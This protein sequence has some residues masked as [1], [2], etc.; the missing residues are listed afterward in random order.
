M[1]TSTS[2]AVHAISAAERRYRNVAITV[3]MLGVTMSGIDTSAVVLGLPVMMRDLSSDLVSMV[4]VIMAYLL[5]ITIL[6]TQVGRLGDMFGRVRMY[7]LGFASFTFGS[8]LCGL[9]ASGPQLIGFRV[10]QGLGG[11][12]IYSNSGAIIADTFPQN[13]RGKAF[14]IT[15]TGWSLGAILGILV[16]GA[17][18]TFLNWRYIFFINLPIGIVATTVGFLMLSERSPRIR[19]KF[20]IIGMVILGTSLF[21]LLLGMTN[22]TG[23]G[24]VPEYVVEV[25]AGV[26]LLPAFV[27]YERRYSS[28]LLDLSLLKQRVLTASIFAAFLQSL[29]SFAVLFLVI[30][31]LQG[32]RDMT[33]WNA[34]LLLIPGYVLGGMIAPVAGRLSDRMGAR[35]V[36]SAGLALQAC[37]FL[38]YLTLGLTTSTYVVVVGAILN[39]AGSSSFFP[40]NNSAVMASAPSRAYGVV[41]GLLR[42]FSNVG[43][44]CSFAVALLVAS[45]SIPRQMAFEIFLGVGR[46]Q[47]S[48]S[49]AFVTGMHAALAG[50]I[51][52]I[53][54][55]LILS[56]LRGKEARTVRSPAA[57]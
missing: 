47:G 35:V 24:F 29:A 15:G 12:L 5:V 27:A 25:A 45:L 54:V 32:P 2:G 11:S 28:P 31:Y 19:A 3:V 37:G 14:G 16:G 8:L 9:S 57:A 43:M 26:V 55:A 46:I 34:S 36:A 42:T 41:S 17:F 53:I 22:I 52:V 13:E 20:D 18:V 33:P 49:S 21:F 1:S 56:V 30:M 7:N 38:V 4:W 51:S 48:L 40:A 10:V 23:S 50:S 6:G 39:G 44:V